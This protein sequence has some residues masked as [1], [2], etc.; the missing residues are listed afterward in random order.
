ML[1][2]PG[3]APFFGQNVL[4]TL[5]SLTNCILMETP[6]ITSMIQILNR[7]AKNEVLSVVDL[8]LFLILLKGASK[9]APLIARAFTELFQLNLAGELQYAYGL[10][11]AI[12]VVKDLN[13]NSNIDAAV[14]NVFDYE[15]H[16]ESWEHFFC[17][18]QAFI[19]FVK[20]KLVVGLRKFFAATISR[21]KKALP[22]VLANKSSVLRL[23]ELC[24]ESLNKIQNTEEQGGV[25]VFERRRRRGTK[26]YI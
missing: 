20:T 21:C 22:R 2:N 15:L 19:F 25:V 8:L 16:P 18:F 12:S 4:E 10:R 24:P 13:E 11:E 17:C 14:A 23:T 1:A 5:G 9:A 26:R 6:S 7:H 3:V